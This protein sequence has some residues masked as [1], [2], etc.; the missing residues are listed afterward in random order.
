MHYAYSECM[1]IQDFTWAETGERI[2]DLRLAAGLTQAALA[3]QAG[4]TQPAITR[5]E[6]GETAPQL[7]T[8]AGIAAVLGTSVRV[9][10]CGQAPPSGDLSMLT[11]IESVLRSGNQVAIAALKQGLTIAKVILASRPSKKRVELL[12]DSVPEGLLAAGAGERRL[13]VYGQDQDR[14]SFAKSL[15]LSRTTDS[16]NNPRVKSPRGK[17]TNRPDRLSEADRSSTQP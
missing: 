1:A 15:A 4:I 6:N 10:V 5:I 16:S 12:R 7:E 13:T 17:S 8:L 3:E 11:D 14:F 9:L 2:R